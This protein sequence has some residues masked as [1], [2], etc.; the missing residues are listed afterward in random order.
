MDWFF[1][2]QDIWLD[3]YNGGLG[4][5]YSL[6]TRNVVDWLTSAINQLDVPGTDNTL[7][8]AMLTAVKWLIAGFLGSDTTVLGLM[9]GVALPTFILVS[10]IKWIIGIVT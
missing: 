3:I 7:A 10:L 9:F 1:E 5:I 6:F 4:D 8:V 2:L